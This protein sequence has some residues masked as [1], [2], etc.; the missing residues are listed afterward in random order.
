MYAVCVVRHTASHRIFVSISFWREVE[1]PV[2]AALS[3]VLP[4]GPQYI[5]IFNRRE[6][7]LPFQPLSFALNENHKLVFSSKMPQ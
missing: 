4:V 6:T 2:P 1:S 5:A 7:S 3:P